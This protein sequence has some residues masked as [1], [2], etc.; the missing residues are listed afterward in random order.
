MIPFYSNWL[1]KRVRAVNRSR[2][3]SAVPP[4]AHSGPDYAAITRSEHEARRREAQHSRSSQKLEMK[5]QKRWL[6]DKSAKQRA[7]DFAYLEDVRSGALEARVRAEHLP[8]SCEPVLRRVDAR[9]QDIKAK[10]GNDVTGTGQQHHAQRGRSPKASGTMVR[11]AHSPSGFL[12]SSSTCFLC[13]S[14]YR[15][16]SCA[17]QRCFFRLCT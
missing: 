17:S 5:Q 8:E 16:Q 7:R 15:Y 2:M 9:V 6:K 4:P 1:A 14:G 3:R 13:R 11:T 10:Y 12:E